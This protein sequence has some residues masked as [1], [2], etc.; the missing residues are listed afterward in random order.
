MS[1]RRIVKIWADYTL[2]Q[3]DDKTYVLIG[4][5]ATCPTCEV[6]GNND[7]DAIKSCAKAL[8]ARK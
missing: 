8:R 3:R 4:N 5:A 1:E 2:V 7:K 6:S